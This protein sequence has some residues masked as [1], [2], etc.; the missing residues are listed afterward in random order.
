VRVVRLRL[1]TSIALTILILLLSNAGYHLPM[2]DESRRR[3]THGAQ[4][5]WSNDYTPHDPV[6]ITNNSDFSAQGWPGNGTEERPYIIE[7][8]EINDGPACINVTDT[9]A[10]FEIRNCALIEDSQ[11]NN[12]G[13]YLRNVTNGVIQDCIIDGQRR[14]VSLTSSP[15]CSLIANVLNNTNI[16]FNLDDC[17]CCFIENN[18]AEPLY[19]YGYYLQKS[20]NCVVRRNF[21]SGI[22]AFHLY[23][24]DGCDL[25]QNVADC[26]GYGFSI[27][28]SDNCTVL[29]NNI[30]GEGRG[31]SMHFS[32]D[33]EVIR[34]N[35]SD[36]GSGIHLYGCDYCTILENS[37]SFNLAYGVRLGE[38]SNDNVIYLNRLACNEESNGFDEGG[39]NSWDNGSHGNYWGDYF[40]NGSYTVPGS[41]GNI[42]RHPYIL[43]LAPPKIDN[44][45]D[46]EYRTGTIGHSI[47]WHPLDQTPESF[48]IFRNG[49]LIESGGWNGS[50]I[51]I[52][53]DGWNV[54]E[55][56]I[57]LVVYDV[58]G[59][60]AMD[61]VTVI[62]IPFIDPFILGFVVLSLAGLVVLVVA[63]K[64]KRLP[65]EGFLYSE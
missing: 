18:S 8:L 41:A 43:D 60:Y 1:E 56:H 19:G 53:I 9:T 61:T 52:D 49:P 24:S 4:C 64:K 50:D 55:Y 6:I 65:K 44:P 7:G 33:N 26:E 2:T 17:C 63:Y 14:G 51:S 35:F 58:E 12:F 11:N 16:G 45:P 38:F 54:G 21:F 39:L 29:E 23:F 47:T 32:H 62:V 15:N 42:D 3:M 27:A 36:S 57:T 34:N 59:R 37:A 13:I 46:I 48:E 31:L 40:G 25:I 10:F 30:C 20:P 5:D 22:E 28:N